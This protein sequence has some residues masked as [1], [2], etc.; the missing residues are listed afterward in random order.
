[1]EGVVIWAMSKKKDV[2]FW[3]GFPNTI[4]QNMNQSKKKSLNQI[5]EPKTKHAKNELIITM[6]TLVKPE[7]VSVIF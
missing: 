6:F 4:E 3:D 1:V 5:F 7:K 2:F